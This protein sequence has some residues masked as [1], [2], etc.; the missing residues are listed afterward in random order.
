MAG[1]KAARN[2][3]EALVSP[4]HRTSSSLTGLGRISAHSITYMVFLCISGNRQQDSRSTGYC[5]CHVE[6]ITKCMQTQGKSKTQGE[7]Q[8]VGFLFES[9][10]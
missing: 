8:P 7:L 10:S 1:L 5:P 2:I 6:S 4:F 9:L 3:R